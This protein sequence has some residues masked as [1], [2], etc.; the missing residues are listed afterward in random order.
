M[1]LGQAEQRNSWRR[2]YRGKYDGDES[3]V[4]IREIRIHFRKINHKNHE[5]MLQ[6]YEITKLQDYKSE[7]DKQKQWLGLQSLFFNLFQFAFGY[8][9]EYFLMNRLHLYHLYT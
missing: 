3:K 7:I 8:H 2:Y 5:I 9:L 4:P 6:F 1:P